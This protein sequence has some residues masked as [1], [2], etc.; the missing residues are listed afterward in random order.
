MSNRLICS[1]FLFL[2]MAFVLAAQPGE[3]SFDIYHNPKEVNSFLKSW[4]SKYPQ[5]TKLI[6]IGKSSGKNDLFVFRIA[7]RG[8]GSPDPDSRPAIFVSANIA[9]KKYSTNC[10]KACVFDIIRPGRKNATGSGSTSS[11]NISTIANL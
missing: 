7:A 5:L 4:S 3:L 9:G 2:S 8:K 1:L 10:T 6:S 11:G